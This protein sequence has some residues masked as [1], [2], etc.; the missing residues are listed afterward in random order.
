MYPNNQS[1]RATSELVSTLLSHFQS[2]MSASAK[3]L[4]SQKIEKP[5][6]LPCV[7]HSGLVVLKESSSAGLAKLSTPRT[8]KKFA[9]LPRIEHIISQSNNTIRSLMI[10]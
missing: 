2:S 1:K 9:A 3:Y 6:R 4:S 7:S 10:I 5:R 8:E